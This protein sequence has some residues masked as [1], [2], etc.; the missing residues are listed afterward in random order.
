MSRS[1]VGGSQIARRSKATCPL[2]GRTIVRR[3]IGAAIVELDPEVLGVVPEGDG[4]RRVNARRL[5]AEQCERYAWA[6][7]RERERAEAAR[8][9]AKAKPRRAPG[10]GGETVDERR[11][12]VLAAKLGLDEPGEG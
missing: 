1:L 11:R 4:A 9:A 12:R 7:A 2:C 6:A 8:A 3:K 5:H 10:L